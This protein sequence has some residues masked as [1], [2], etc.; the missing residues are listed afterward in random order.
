VQSEQAL[1]WFR[2]QWHL[3]E[4]NTRKPIDDK[5]APP[6]ESMNSQSRTYRRI[7]IHALKLVCVFAVAVVLLIA[8][9]ASAQDAGAFYKRNCGA[10]HTIGGG[11]LLG[12]DLKN[13][14]G[15]KDRK[16]LIEFL[17]D[18]KAA[19]AAGDPYGKQILAEAKGMVMPQVKG[20]DRQMAGALLDLIA[21]RSNGGPASAAAADENTFTAAD[22]A[23]GRDLVT[24]KQRLANGGPACAACH[25]FAALPAPGG[26]A[27]GPDLTREF[28][29]LGGARGIGM[30]LGSPPTPAMQSVYARHALEPREIRAITAWLKSQPNVKQAQSARPLFAIIGVAGCLIGLLLMNLV[31][32]RRF[33]AVRAPLIRRTFATS[34][35]GKV[36]R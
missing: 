8:P 22:T 16:W 14:E 15:R 21:A 36:N 13:V 27:L 23:L 12:P 10:C 26:G 3:R 20:V 34:F 28:T 29:R 32:R 2:I 1:V 25:K 18:P 9:S 11:R 35:E 31:W 17:V 19:I 6:G 24:G 5:F 33:T 30:W 4:K 7:E